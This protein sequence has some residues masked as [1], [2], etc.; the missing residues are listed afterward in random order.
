MSVEKRI[1]E[2]GM[3]LPQPPAPAGNYKR[4]VVA[5]ELVFVS[6]QFPIRNGKLEYTGRVGAELTVEDG[7]RAAQL[8]VLN[9]LGQLKFMLGDF[10]RLREIVR[11]E[12]HVA[13][14]PG[15]FDQPKVL[16]GA[17]DL[18][19]QA[20]VERAGHARTA[21][22]HPQLPLNAAVEIVVIATMGDLK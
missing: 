5:G 2:L 8:A 10:D 15:F 6:G 3:A 16:D 11:L 4:A 22:A 1:E 21:F 7:Y 20:L 18:F 19:T 14:A 13:S 12:G 9:V 17:S